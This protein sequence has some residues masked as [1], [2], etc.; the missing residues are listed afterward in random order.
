MKNPDHSQPTP[1]TTS[2]R[3]GRGNSSIRAL[4]LKSAKITRNLLI[5]IALPIAA[6]SSYLAISDDG[7]PPNIPA[8]PLSA[9][10]LY[11]PAVNDKPAIALGKR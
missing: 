3:L 2:N 9:D 6:T 5:W 8:I 10:P 7:T 1:E 4:G 11:A